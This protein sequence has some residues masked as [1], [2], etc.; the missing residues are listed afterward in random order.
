[1]LLR[2][3]ISYDRQLGNIVLQ[4]AHDILEGGI[5]HLHIGEVE[6]DAGRANL[7]RLFSAFVLG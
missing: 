2:L 1:M 4:M 3:Q 6:G 7:T 5:R